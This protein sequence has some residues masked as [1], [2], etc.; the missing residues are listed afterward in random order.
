MTVIG[1]VEF[2]WL[3]KSADRLEMAEI[4]HQSEY[5]REGGKEQEQR[6]GIDL[7]DGRALGGL[8][9]SWLTVPV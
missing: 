8:H 5:K 1:K 7:S 3:K 4:G 2:S 6:Q 9:A